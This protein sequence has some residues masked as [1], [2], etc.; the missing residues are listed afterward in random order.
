M[1]YR[2]T[3]VEVKEWVEEAPGISVH[4]YNSNSVGQ[5]HTH[6]ARGGKC[7]NHCSQ[8]H[9]SDGRYYCPSHGVNHHGLK[10]AEFEAAFAADSHTIVR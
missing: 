1:A 6:S 4:I 3:R 7:V 9:V 10:G 8:R 2:Y 5:L